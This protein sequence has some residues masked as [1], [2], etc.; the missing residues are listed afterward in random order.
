MTVRGGL[1]SWGRAPQECLLAT[2]QG[3]DLAQPELVILIYDHTGEFKDDKNYSLTHNNFGFLHEL[4]I[5]EGTGKFY[6]GKRRKD[7]ELHNA[8]N[9]EEVQCRRIANDPDLPCPK[10]WINLLSVAL[11][12]PLIAPSPPSSPDGSHW[13]T[14]SS[15]VKDTELQT[16]EIPMHLKTSPVTT[17]HPTMTSTQITTVMT[18][19]FSFNLRPR[20]N[21]GPGP[22]PFGGN[23]G[24][25]QE[26]QE[27]ETQVEEV[28]GIPSPEDSW[29]E[30]ESKVG[31]P[32]PCPSYS[33]ETAQRPDCSS[34]LWPPTYDWMNKF[35][36][37]TP[38]KEGWHSP[39][40]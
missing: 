13:S 9:W 5:E 40:P 3:S 23:P 30:E 12:P 4:L 27:E 2:L 28:W 1:R 17:T 16:Q 7:I 11:E 31:Q 38:T 22:N 8:I 20:V 29:P 37:S 21:S 18:H 35:H 6:L 19:A 34:E 14:E 15:E 33:M 26:G 25:T 10:E 24:E 39:W 36:L 32:E